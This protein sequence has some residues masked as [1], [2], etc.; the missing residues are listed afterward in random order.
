[1]VVALVC[2]S[3]KL[4]PTYRARKRASVER[5]GEREHTGLDMHTT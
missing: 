2:V 4:Y 3:V 1:V 5:K